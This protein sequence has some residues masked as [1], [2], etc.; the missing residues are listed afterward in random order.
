MK[1]G[2]LLKILLF[3]LSFLVTIPDPRGARAASEDFAY[4]IESHH[5]IVQIVPSHQFIKAEDRI[6]LHGHEGK[7]QTLSFTLNSGLKVTRI[8]DLRTAQSLK[9]T[10]STLSHEI[11]KINVSLKTAEPP[12]S[13]SISYEGRID[14]PVVRE[15][16]LQFVRGDHT[17]GVIS[18]EG[19]YLSA[20]SGWYPDRP[21]SRASF[22]VEA[23]IPEP[24][25]IVTQGELLTEELKSGFWK[26]EWTCE[27]PSESLTLVAGI[28]SVRRRD[29]NGVKTSTYFF[30]EDDSFSEAFL[31][32]AGEYLKIYTELLGPFPFKKFDI[33][34]NFFSSG[35]GIPTFTLLDPKAIRQ[36]KEFLRPG[37][38]DHEIVHSWW[39]HYVSVKPGPGNWV[40]ALTTY[41][42][43][44]YYK[45][46]K[47]GE[48]AARKHRQDVLQKYAVQVPLSGEYPLREFEDKQ[49]ELDS[50]IGYG[51]GSMVFHM[52]RKIVGRD[53]FFEIL[54]AFAG[55]YGGKPASWEDIRTVFEAST[56][57]DL[58]WFFSQW[59]DRAGG[60]RV[61][62]ENVKQNVIPKGY[63]LTG[64]LVQ[65][66]DL[67][68]FTVPV[69]IESGKSKKKISLEVARR[70]TPF[71]IDVAEM[72]LSL[73]IDPDAE[74]FR[75]LYPEEVVPGLN[76]LLEDPEKVFVLPGKGDEESRKI[77]GELAARA[78]ER[79]G[80][81]IVVLDELKKEEIENSSLMLFGEAWRSPV[82]SALRS[83]LPGGVLVKDGVVTIHGKE[84]GGEDESI[85]LT[86]PHPLRPGKWVTVYFGKS[87][88]A[89]SRASLIFFYGWDSYL[90]F[91]NGRPLQRG[92][93]PS[94]NSFTTHRFSL[95]E[96]LDQVEPRKLREHV[97]YLASPELKG[98][99][100]GTPEYRKAQAYIIKELEELGITPVRQ[101]FSIIVKD[102]E[103]VHLDIEPSVR[104]LPLKAVPFRFSKDGEWKGP[105]LFA[106]SVEGIKDLA[107]RSAVAYLDPSDPLSP[108]AVLKK[109]GEIRER[110]PSALLYF[111]KV[112][113]LDALSPYITYP[114]YFPPEL[115]KSFREREAKGY[116]MNRAAEAS[117]AAAMAEETPPA[118]EI[119]AFV[120]PYSP[121]EEEAIRSLFDQ[122]G[123]F[124]ELI[125]R[126]KEM[127]LS[128][129]NIGGIISGSDPEKKAGYLVLGAHYDHLGVNERN[130]GFYPGAD[131]NAS[132]VAALLEVARMLA[133]RKADL[134]RSVLVLFFG[135]EE[136]GLKGSE[137]FVQNPFVPLARM[138]AM[139][140][141]DSIGRSA[142][143]RE[144]FFI[145]NSKYPELAARSRRFLD[146][147]GLKEGRDI[148][149][150][151]FRFGSDHFSF[152]RKG[153]PALDLFSSDY[154]KL[155]TLEDD[156]EGIDFE[157]LAN[158]ARLVYL[159]AYE[160]LT[161]P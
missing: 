90:I 82:F 95:R 94:R 136:W 77:Y 78:K 23:V 7:E 153:I 144:V 63:Y 40:E 13:L 17:S 106:E 121:G 59:L 28:Y 2:R 104:D 115:E 152:H 41:C 30:P 69:V 37:A 26:T 67:Y 161:E 159:T 11:K 42:T 148:D 3:F 109:I 68:R 33:V 105:I 133:Q 64:E 54:R 16:A 57:R 29:V 75:R 135:G 53:R 158:I 137:Y 19:V 32:A 114:S 45:E 84:V 58:D 20:T 79:K 43:N 74:I 155:H 5:I 127:R 65:E 52:L 110:S 61:R 49:D 55:R 48:E 47:M 80:G 60:P 147:L 138:K 140:S 93:F 156:P 83:K 87:H 39:G 131:D 129:A 151:A 46:L 14:D 120:I 25:R 117:R 36:G 21:G 116:G 38:L 4:D 112:K 88:E 44:Y 124:I 22:R 102:I 134:G 99:F 126:F 141:L 86:Y 15:R 150:Y 24:F 56:G 6:R 85:L 76:A 130:G 145:G 81:R 111:I 97:S 62:L 89:L 139:F 50:Q 103:F 123:A 35:Y 160:F 92:N 146:Q 128:D 72:P 12:V 101:P 132:G 122:G 8:A 119:P 18:L 10:E 51:K 154:K 31:D 113:G 96:G 71:S 98:R 107:E 118:L 91:K 1:T 9:W 125:L 157:K 143:E 149:R 142:G 100:P 66:G 70:R 73:S 34:Q 27:L 108:E